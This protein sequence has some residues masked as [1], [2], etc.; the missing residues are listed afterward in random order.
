MA[1]ARPGARLVALAYSMGANYLL[2]S[3]GEAGT[4]SPLSLAI[5]VA[6]VWDMNA[7]AEHHFARSPLSWTM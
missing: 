6:N 2:K 5:A 4:K 7:M 3:L 1:S